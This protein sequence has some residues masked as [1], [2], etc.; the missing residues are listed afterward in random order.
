MAI[1]LKAARVNAGLTQLE[2]CEKLG[3]SQPTLIK[4]ERAESFPN[5]VQLKTIEKLY[6]V[7]Y[8]DIDFLTESSVKMNQKGE[9]WHN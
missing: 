9:Q 7:G 5:I 6:G 8:D 1:T 2:V 3:V 4:W